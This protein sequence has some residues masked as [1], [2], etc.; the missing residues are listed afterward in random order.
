[1]SFNGG[2]DRG[3]SLIEILVAVLILG[4][5]AVAVTGGLLASVKLSD[6]HRKQATGG[7][8]ARDYA[9]SVSRYVAGTGYVPCAAAG[10]GS[11]YAPGTVGFSAPSGYTASVTSVRYWPASGTTWPTTCPSPDRGLQQVTLQVASADGRATETSVVVLRKPCGQGS[12]C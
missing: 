11:P 4:L 10:A 8:Y 5:T 12:T 1:V 3:E 7:A 2:D 6:V 9:E